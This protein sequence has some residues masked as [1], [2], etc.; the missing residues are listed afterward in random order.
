MEWCLDTRE[1]GAL[2]V[3]ES[4]IC[5][6]VGRHVPSSALVDLVRPAVRDALGGEGRRR[7]R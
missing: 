3:L 2:A 7:D 4:A 5:A 6:H 1:D